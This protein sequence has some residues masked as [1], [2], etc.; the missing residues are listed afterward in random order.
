MTD[1]VRGR[2]DSGTTQNSLTQYPGEEPLSHTATK[3]RE[4]RDRELT[5]LGLLE[6]AHGKEPAAVRKIV[7]HDMTKYP[8]LP[9]THRNHE[10]RN[11][12]IVKLE[13]E[14][15]ILDEERFQ[16]IMEAIAHWAPEPVFVP[17]KS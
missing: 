14:N 1:A 11:D 5:L 17:L 8:P 13:R 2:N 6:V 10:S 15:E 9:A 16:A 3:Y 4:D 12:T 7:F